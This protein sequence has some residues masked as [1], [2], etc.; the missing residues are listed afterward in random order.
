M[1]QNRKKQLNLLSLLIII[2]ITLINFPQTQQIDC[3]QRYTGCETCSQTECLNC[4]QGYGL[5]NGQCFS[6]AYYNNI[7]C[8]Q[9]DNVQ[10]CDKCAN[11][12]YLEQIQYQSYLSSKCYECR[13]G[14]AKCEDKESCI[15]CEGANR[16]PQQN[17]QCKESYEE[18]LGGEC[19]LSC[20]VGVGV[21]VGVEFL[22]MEEVQFR[23]LF[24]E[25][26][27]LEDKEGFFGVFGEEQCYYAFEEEFVELFGEEPR[28]KISVGDGELEILV[29]FS[30]T[31]IYDASSQYVRL[32]QKNFFGEDCDYS[33]VLQDIQG[34]QGNFATYTSDLNPAIGQSGVQIQ[35]N[36]EKASF[37]INNVQNDGKRDLKNLSWQ[38]I[39]SSNPQENLDEIN[40]AF[41]NFVQKEG[42]IL[43]ELF[44]QDSVYTLKIDFENY[45]GNQ[46]S[47]QQD[48]S[49]QKDTLNVEINYKDLDLMQFLFSVQNENNIK[50][51]KSSYSKYYSTEA[52]KFA[53]DSQFLENFGYYPTCKVF[54]NALKQIEILVQLSYW[55]IYDPSYHKISLKMENLIQ[56]GCDYSKY[57]E[58][59]ENY[60]GN[61]KNYNNNKLPVIQNNQFQFSQGCNFLNFNILSILNDGKRRLKKISWEMVSSSDGEENLVLINDAIKATGNNNRSLVLGVENFV[62]GNFYQLVV[63]MTNFLDKQNQF[64]YE[65]EFKEKGDISIDLVNIQSQQSVLTVKENDLMIFELSYE[66]CEFVQNYVNNIQYEYFLTV[67]NEKN[68]Q[69]Y[70][71]NISVSDAVYQIEY[72]PIFETYGEKLYIK[73]VTQ[74]E[75]ISNQY[76]LQYMVQQQSYILKI[77][78]GNRNV[79]E[80]VEILNL[81]ANIKELYYGAYNEVDNNEIQSIMWSG[82][83]LD[84]G[85][86]ITNSDGEIF[87]FKQ[88]QLNQKVDLSQID[89]KETEFKFG[90]EVEYK[91]L[92]KS[93]SVI[94]KIGEN[95]QDLKNE[96]EK[97]EISEFIF[98]RQI[99]CKEDIQGGVIFYKGLQNLKLE[100]YIFRVSLVFENEEIGYKYYYYPYFI[101]NLAQFIDNYEI[102]DEQDNIAQI[103]INIQ[104]IVSGQQ[105][106]ESY[107]INFKIPFTQGVLSLNPGFGN[108]ISTVFELSA[109]GF[110]DDEGQLKYKFLYKPDSQ[111][112]QV[113]S[114]NQFS[115]SNTLSTVLPY[116]D[117]NPCIIVQVINK[118]GFILEAQQSL[119]IKQQGDQQQ[120]IQQLYQQSQNE[121]LFKQINQYVI[122]FLE[123]TQNYNENTNFTVYSD[124]FQNIFDIFN[125]LLNQQI[126]FDYENTLMD[127]LSG[128][129]KLQQEF[130]VLKDLTI[131]QL[132]SLID[133]IS[134]I[135]NKEQQQLQQFNQLKSEY[136]Q[137]YKFAYTLK[138]HNFLERTQ[139]QLKLLNNAIKVKQQLFDQNSENEGQKRILL[140]YQN[141]EL[142]QVLD[143]ISE[144]INSFSL[145]NTDYL[146]Y[147]GDYYKVYAQRMTYNRVKKFLYGDA[148]NAFLNEIDVNLLLSINDQIEN[149]FID[150]DNSSSNTYSVQYVEYYQNIFKD[151]EK[152]P[153]QDQDVSVYNLDIRQQNQADNKVNQED[154]KLKKGYNI[155]QIFKYQDDSLDKDKYVCIQQD[156]NDQSWGD[157]N[158][159]TKKFDDYIICQC[160]TLQVT[161]VVYDKEF[162]YVKK[163]SFIS[164][165][166]F[167]HWLLLA[168]VL[169][170]IIFMVTGYFK[171]KQDSYQEVLVVQ[172]QQVEENA[173]KSNGVVIQ[174]NGNFNQNNDVNINNLDLAQ[175]S[176][177]KKV[178]SQS[179]RVPDSII[180]MKKKMSSQKQANPQFPL[181]TQLQILHHLLQIYFV[182]DER[183]S[184]V[185]R[186]LNYT[187]K[188]FVTIGLT[189]IAV[190]MEFYQIVLIAF[191]ICAILSCYTRVMYQ[192]EN[193]Y[194]SQKLY[195]VVTTLTSMVLQIY[196]SIIAI[197]F[198]EK[199]N[200]GE[201]SKCGPAILIGFLID[202]IIFQTLM[203]FLGYYIYKKTKSQSIF[204]RPIYNIIMIQQKLQ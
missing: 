119:N 41:S 122:I 169:L 193:F 114:L 159:E 162:K 121:N 76:D 136:A 198:N 61:F 201:S 86:Q 60:E 165:L 44:Q 6:C 195:K 32:N 42:E 186:F 38:V 155:Q 112:D 21:G 117:T 79:P 142:Q 7:G 82:A 29:N 161:S 171:D 22:G 202:L 181:G 68:E 85:E 166:Q 160:N 20:W 13:E 72:K 105:Y 99:G 144:Q 19:E 84:S 143:Q 62:M 73:I 123:I 192:F 170:E 16:D 137:V 25:G 127:V 50:S 189:I 172:D 58:N 59:L 35:Q 33:S 4:K 18:G 125:E 54:K 80:D 163:E 51:I 53:F 167:L 64:V 147:S 23:V 57:L 174:K 153:Y 65:F 139:K 75:G 126:N 26:K 173:K 52:C 40:A 120:L 37:Q 15:E 109:D 103:K 14:C 3:E 197:L 88:N 69:I 70:T 5:E 138:N 100:N 150:G 168:V 98:D 110:F 131:E 177:E 45:Y 9:C 200:D 47:Y 130:N 182:Y 101:I 89:K 124:F 28:C 113:Y 185:I 111:L 55:T 183:I 146:L 108:S 66:A 92:I 31:T 180:R 179:N 30:Y 115:S 11:G 107:Q 134:S 145:P 133:M 97:I 17:C 176:V 154:I 140:S 149:G 71:E 46:G 56:G 204:T 63:S 67:N 48:F 156:I 78:G 83:Y 190:D 39:K 12:Y 94:I 152:F 188:Y 118:F 175:L 158:C 178:S 1:R 128:I 135:K 196:F 132:D 2:F 157:K 10:Q 93:Q 8:I 90:V 74:K 91:Q 102:F 116:S 27:G 77:E 96:I 34:Y 184:R 148:E 187:T 43:L 104:N 194:K 81:Y 36:C 199:L 49:I 95:S 24:G 191:G 164:K 203:G 151:D 129:F 141:Q 87:Q 106:E